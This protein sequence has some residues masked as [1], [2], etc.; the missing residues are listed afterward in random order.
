MYALTLENS[1]IRQTMPVSE[2]LVGTFT[3]DCA[4]WSCESPVIFRK[5]RYVYSRHSRLSHAGH[6][7]PGGVSSQAG[8][9]VL[10]QLDDVMCN[11]PAP[12]EAE[13]S[14]SGAPVA[15]L[16]CNPINPPVSLSVSQGMSLPRLA[17]KKIALKVV[18]APLS[19]VQGV[20]W[21][22]SQQCQLGLGSS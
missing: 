16:L 7:M 9:W 11:D 1:F 8:P 5:S 6:P 14:G 3:Q 4:V 13:C 22:F 12:L 17:V 10:S 15:I 20:I 21:L 19:P 2:S 18:L